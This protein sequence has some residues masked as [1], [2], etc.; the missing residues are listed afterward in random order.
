MTR[1]DE[2]Q[3][4]AVREYII[5]D[6]IGVSMDD[7][8]DGL[9]ERLQYRRSRK[10]PWRWVG[11]AF[12]VAACLLCLWCGLCG[13]QTLNKYISARTA[14]TLTDRNGE[15]VV[16]C[17]VKDGLPVQCRLVSGHTLDDAMRTVVALLEIHP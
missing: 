10:S 17:H 6:C 14:I 2:A 8:I 12:I 15:A 3:R 1:I 4:A 9:A 5:K 7:Y 11:I 16:K 13:A